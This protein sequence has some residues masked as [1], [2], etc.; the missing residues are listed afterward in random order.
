MLF[1]QM[2]VNKPNITLSGQGDRRAEDAPKDL[3]PRL[4]KQPH[5]AVTAP[6]NIAHSAASY[7]VSYF[8]CLT[9]SQST[10]Y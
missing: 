3:L 10:R 5:I 1:F 2:S 9:G 6:I 4:P 7:Q 8:F